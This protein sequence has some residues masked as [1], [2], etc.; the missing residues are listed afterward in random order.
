MRLFALLHVNDGSF[1]ERR[2]DH[3]NGVVDRVDAV[4]VKGDHAGIDE[5]HAEDDLDEAAD[6]LCQMELPRGIAVF[7]VA[8][9]ADQAEHCSDEMRGDY[10]DQREPLCPV[11]DR[12]NENAHVEHYDAYQEEPFAADHVLRVGEV[13]DDVFDAIVD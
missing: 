10:V 6:T 12:G 7:L 5:Y 13:I 4:E 3:E 2:D 9:G 11:V 8:D 1:P